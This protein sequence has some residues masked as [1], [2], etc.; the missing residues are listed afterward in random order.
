MKIKILLFLAFISHH[1][2]SQNKFDIT[3]FGAKND[4]KTINTISIQK[5]ID[6]CNAS[7]GGTV[8]FPSGTFISGSLVLKS[9][10]SFFLES[11]AILKGSPDVKD[12]PNGMGL[13][14][15]EDL[16]NIAITGQGEINGNGSSFMN[17]GKLHKF[18]DFDKKFVR[19]G[20]DFLKDLNGAGDGPVGYTARPNMMI[21]LMHC[22]RVKLMDVKLADSPNWTIRIGNCEDVIAKGLSIIN[23][24]MVP[25]SDGIHLTTS[26][27]ARI[28]DCHI[29]AGDDAIIVSGFGEEIDVHGGKTNVVRTDYKYGNLTGIAENIVVSNCILS[30]RSAGIRI[31]Y[32]EHNIKDCSFDNIIIRNSNRGIGLFTREKGTI[33]NISF[34]NFTIETR[35]LQ[36]TWW[37]RGEPIHISAISDTEGGI[38]GTI[39]H[40]SFSNFK[41]KSET[42]VVV[43]GT[44]KSIIEDIKLE[45]VD[46]EINNG[47]YSKTYGGNID[48]RPTA[49]F[50][51]NLFKRE[52]P[53]IYM[54]YVKD[55]TIRNS[56][57]KWG[58]DIENFFSNGIEIEN[59]ENLKIDGFNGRQALGNGSSVN[60]ISGKNVTVRN[61][62]SPIGTNIFL[63][64]KN[65]S[66]QRMFS[67]NDLLNSKVGLTPLK[68]EFKN[69]S[70][71][72]YK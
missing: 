17:W 1:I 7:G 22:Q 58:A 10:V 61:C 62:I 38:S 8:Y 33:E 26:R 35:L 25:N 59:F 71:N 14:Y 20:E 66:D 28:S 37:G 15:G 67:G 19:Q 41:I 21:I 70:G 46:L 29:E 72:L 27:S 6:Q 50:E 40:I 24:Q 63:Q 32:G 53:G 69:V 4:G 68:N 2:F 3:A 39:K 16:I 64:L 57:L 13:I 12:Y 9:N 34:S 52:I 56:N 54:N 55:I 44:S 42:G 65:V 11:G 48:L 60:L 51:T 23:N 31:G 49:K 5:A 47:K 18:V 36:G 45:N 30:S 43:Y